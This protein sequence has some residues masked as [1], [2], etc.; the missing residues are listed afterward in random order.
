M[1]VYTCERPFCLDDGIV[2]MKE[3]RFRWRGKVIFLKNGMMKDLCLRHAEEVA[4]DNIL[5]TSGNWKGA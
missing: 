2:Q 1:E 3:L 4:K 5:I